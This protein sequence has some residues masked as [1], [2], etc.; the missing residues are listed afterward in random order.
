MDPTVTSVAFGLG[1]ALALGYL[2][3]NSYVL[4]LANRTYEKGRV[5]D[6]A[7]SAAIAAGALFFL[8]RDGL[9]VAY[10]LPM[11]LLLA[12]GAIGLGLGYGLHKKRNE[13]QSPEWQPRPPNRNGRLVGALL[14][15]IAGGFAFSYLVSFWVNL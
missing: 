15:S 12:V 4:Y 11:S 13:P 8:L 1:C 2:S 14:G 7:G 6:A 9:Q 3:R 5:F 10:W